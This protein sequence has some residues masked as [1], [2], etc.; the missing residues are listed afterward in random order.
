[1]KVD[2]CNSEGLDPEV[3]YA[4]FRDALAQAGRPIVFSICNW[5]QKEPWRWGPRTG[6]LWRT[7]TDIADSWDGNVKW[8]DGA[9]CAIGELDIVDNQ[10]GLEAYA[11]PGHWNDPDMLAVRPAWPIN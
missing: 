9:C 5:G 8:P 11:G 4:K 1:V 2:W 10:L 7:T 6:N 3:Q